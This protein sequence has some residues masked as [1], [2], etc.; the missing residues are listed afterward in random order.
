MMFHSISDT[1]S[2]SHNRRSSKPRSEPEILD[3][4]DE[5]LAYQAK[6]CPQILP[7]KPQS[8]KILI[9]A[10]DGVG[11]GVISDAF[12]N[13]NGVFTHTDPLD[14]LL[15]DENPDS[16]TNV[17]QLLFRLETLMNCNVQQDTFD[18]L[19]KYQTKTI[20]R[21]E[22]VRDSCEKFKGKEDFEDLC[23][24]SSSVLMKI[25]SRYLVLLSKLELLE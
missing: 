15:L 4:L 20:Q 21:N 19:K 3:R 25:C 6:V 8:Q 14:E 11:Y 18:L 24:T 9:V 2:L 7:I 17:D 23:E 22:F 5:I 10:G 16:D 12:G 13:R 1:K